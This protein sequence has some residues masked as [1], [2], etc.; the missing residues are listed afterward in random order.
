[1]KK[2]AL[3]LLILVALICIFAFSISAATTDEYGTVETS[4][5]IDLSK[6][7]T[8]DDV[9]CVLFD[10]TEYHTYPS[11]YIVTSSTDLSASKS[12]NEE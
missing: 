6:M 8:D 9:Y 1:M 7:A 3:F 11:R 10:G 5:T 12:S 4:E 2:S